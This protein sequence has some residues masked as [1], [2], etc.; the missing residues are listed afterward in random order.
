MAGINAVRKLRNAEDFVLGRSEAYIGV[1]I[2]VLIDDLI[3]LG[4]EE[5]YRMF[6]SR[7]EYRLLLRHGS[8]DLRLMEKGYALGLV[9][10]VLYLKLIKKKEAIAAGRSWFEKTRL[11]RL[12]GGLASFEARGL[13]GEL[14][15]QSLK[16]LM[17]RPEV[18]F[19]WFEPWFPLKT[20]NDISIS[21]EIE[22][23]IKYE[24]YI[25]RELGHALRFKAAEGFN[26]DEV[27]GLSNEVLEK[28]KKVR[29]YS[30][31]Q[32]ARIS[33]VTPA[34]LSLLMIALEKQKRMKSQK[35]KEGVGEIP[36]KLRNIS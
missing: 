1:F 27:P 13:S 29:P 36:R 19:S 28:L 8:A 22:F 12:S 23:Q 2:G 25:K 9:P 20:G 18:N 26:Y 16:Q 32:A 10:E 35:N 14:G 33:G 3:T 6:T 34:A 24:G 5:P 21:E 11:A 31:G 30:L 15:G 4:T 17:K 7:A